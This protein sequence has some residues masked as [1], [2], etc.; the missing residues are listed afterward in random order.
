MTNERE[1]RIRKRAYDIWEQEGRVEGKHEAHWQQATE[2][3]DGGSSDVVRKSMVQNPSSSPNEALPL[4][5]RKRTSGGT[6]GDV[7]ASKSQ[8]PSG[9]SK[10]SGPSLEG[11]EP[12]GGSSVKARRPRSARTMD[13]GLASTDAAQGTAA[14]RRRRKSTDDETTTATSVQRSSKKESTRQ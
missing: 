6:A 3:I 13:D 8:A 12:E 7:P 5:A 1:E 2:E 4:R 9:A 11:M 14:Q 10:A